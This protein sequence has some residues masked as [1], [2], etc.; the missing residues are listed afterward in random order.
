VVVIGNMVHLPPSEAEIAGAI[1]SFGVR[2]IAM[3]RGWQLPTAVPPAES[4]VGANADL[5]RKRP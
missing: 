5:K 4:E 1:L 3:R 2:F